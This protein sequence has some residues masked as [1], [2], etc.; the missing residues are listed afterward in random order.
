MNR[1]YTVDSV[2]KAWYTANMIF[3]TDYMKDERCSERAGYPI[4]RSTADGHYYD[5]ICDLGC[6]LEV[7]LSTGETVRISIKEPEQW[8][9]DGQY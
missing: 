3:P 7:N 5:Y 6:G 2:S 1:S 9:Y 4:Y 8:C